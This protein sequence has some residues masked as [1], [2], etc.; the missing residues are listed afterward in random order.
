[1][2]SHGV[3]VTVESVSLFI[4]FVD[5]FLFNLSGRRIDVGRLSE[6][7]RTCLKEHGEPDASSLFTPC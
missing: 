6:H 7:S 1:M 2:L 3:R 4:E 5:E